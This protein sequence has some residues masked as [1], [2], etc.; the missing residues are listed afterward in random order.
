M[1]NFNNILIIAIYSKLYVKSL[2]EE[3]KLTMSKS[4]LYKYI[5]LL[6]AGILLITS[7][8]GCDSQASEQAKG[9]NTKPFYNDRVAT[10]RIVMSEEDW[11]ATHKNPGAE[12]YV[13]ADFWFDDKLV[14]DVAVRPKGNSSL[15]SVAR[16]GT[17]RMS[18]KV[19]FNFFNSA[20]TFYG[21]KKVNL[22]NGFSDP[23]LIRE[24]LSYDLFEQ[25][26]LPTPRSSFVDLWVNDIHLGLYTMVEQID[27]TFL[28][29]NFA[30]ANGN[31]YKPQMPAAFLTWTEADLEEWQSEQAATDQGYEDDSLD[32]NLGGGKLSDILRV[33]EQEEQSE[34]MSS[35]DI[36]RRD[37]PFGGMPPWNI[38]AF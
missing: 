18:L 26:G 19:D 1:G 31:L 12:E 37:I 8:A 15:M 30:D 35:G 2:K 4:R 21:L 22:N 33:L 17:E 11:E 7:L 3:N 27:K 16:S 32:V 24:V 36:L 34:D 14:P 13:R 10:V 9:E 25:M 6:L 38:E 28:S 5:G 29:N 20:R 23:T